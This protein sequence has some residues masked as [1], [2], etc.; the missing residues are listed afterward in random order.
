MLISSRDVPMYLKPVSQG[1]GGNDRPRRA[2]V[3]GGNYKQ[4]FRLKDGHEVKFER[5]GERLF[6]SPSLLLSV[7]VA[8]RSKSIQYIKSHAL[9]I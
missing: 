6:P 4:I 9:K 5:G 7:E 1:G 2:S 3:P 8:R